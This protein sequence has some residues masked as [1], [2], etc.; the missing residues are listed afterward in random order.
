MKGR[1]ISTLL[2]WGILVGAIYFLGAHGALLLTVA[3]AL[4]SQFEFYQ[5]AGQKQHKPL[6]Y[7]GMAFGALLLLV[8]FFV[9]PTLVSPADILIVAVLAFSIVGLLRKPRTPPIE[10]IAVTLAGLLLLPFTLSYIPLTIFHFGGSTEGLMMAVW[11]VAATKFTDA[12]A[13]ISGMAFGKHRMAPVLSPKKTWE[14]AIGGVLGAS[15]VSF[16]LVWGFQDLF[17]AGFSPWLA[18]LITPPI[19]IVSILADLLESAFKREAGVKDSGKMIPGIGG[20]FD[21]TDSFMLSAPT[22]YY[23]ARIVIG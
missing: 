10:T 8:P 13:L 2:L 21:L 22:A 5:L 23:L 17:P 3:V 6:I 1:I 9:S 12:G 11:I 18:A 7:S 15:L 14:G 20:V 19:S 16:L 4:L